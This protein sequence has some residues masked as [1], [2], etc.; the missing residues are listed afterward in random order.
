MD[1]KEFAKNRSFNENENKNMDN[2]NA[3]KV[4]ENF[5][6]KYKDYSKNDLTTEIEKLII[7]QKK[8]GTFN[9]QNL[10]STLQSFSAFIPQNNMQ[11]LKELIEKID[12]Q[13]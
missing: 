1:L 5:Y 4:A 2:D 8:A 11:E 12:G 7:A 13:N 9:K 6:N 10:L 3:Q